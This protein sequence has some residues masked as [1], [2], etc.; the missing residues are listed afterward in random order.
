AV[1]DL[2]WR[3]ARQGR[4]LPAL[5]NQDGE[6]HARWRPV[7]DRAYLRAVDRLANAVPPAALADHEPGDHDAGLSVTTDAVR[8]LTDAEVRAAL[9]GEPPLL[10]AGRRDPTR[11]NATT[12]T[13][14]TRPD[15]TTRTDATRTARLWL[16]ALTST[17]ARITGADPAELTDLERRLALWYRSTPD[18]SGPLRLCFRLAEPLGADPTDPEGW[19]SDDHWQLEFLLQSTREPAVTVE[20]RAFWA[21]GDA[22]A[23]LARTVPA[24]VQ[25]FLD[26]LDRAVRCFPGLREAFR[27]PSPAGLRLTRAGALEFLR[28][29]A[30]VLAEAGFGVLLP[31]WW[32]RPARLGLRMTARLADPGAVATTS[33]IDRDAVV[34]FDWQAAI[35]ALRLSGEELGLLA[36]AT[37]PLVRLRGRW[38]VV[39]PDQIAAA[40]DFLKREGKGTGTAAEVLREV[41]APEPSAG[42]LPVLGV[43]AD[44][45]LGDLLAGTANGSAARPVEPLR[46]P[47]GFEADFRAD[48]R[49][50]Q[51][52]GL[53]WLATL[54][55]LG[56]GAVL[57]DDMGLGKTVQTLALLVLERVGGPGAADDYADYADSGDS[58]DSGRNLLICPM[59]LVGNWQRE[60]ARFAPGLRV[61]V[62]HGS[63]RRG[64]DLLR[65]VR[66]V[67]LV[68][69][70]YAVAQRDLAL[71]QRVSWRR[72]VVDEAQ[73][74]KNRASGASRAIRSL[75]ARHRIALTGT[76]VENRLADLHAV[77]DFANPGLFGS[78]EQFKERYSVPIE[79]H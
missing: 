50:Y 24:P 75:P 47:G 72:V 49:P 22:P 53:A 56:L 27:D 46:L 11:A 44:G 65:A 13:Y 63:G 31:S 52:R 43:D 16:Q 23:A 54:S 19:T 39:D 34:G 42:G 62:H 36:A 2:A 28:D 15:A 17:S 64:G 73:Y 18:S 8:T 40:L 35:G 74:I 48:L 3:T 30:P 76:P 9:D 66:E 4:V 29:G 51:Q 26:E 41:F 67:D 32:Q 77:L 33:L 58:G 69:T 14:A 45:W 10:P 71:L 78:T 6:P 57:A 12:G 20:A 55:R 79:R 61:H 37:V 60:A 68:I 70:T 25:A 1:H 5:E 21:G 38:T 59:S 7:S